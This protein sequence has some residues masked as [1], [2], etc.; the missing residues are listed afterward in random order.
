MATIVLLEHQLQPRLGIPYM[1]HLFAQHWERWGH[2]V[3][4]HRGVSAPPAADLAI[5]HVDLTVVP[6]PYRELAS[7]YPR[8]LNART[9]DIRK[10]AYSQA[11]VRKGDPWTGQVLVKTDANHGGHVD[12]ALRRMALAEGLANDVP[13]RSLM[14]HYYL[15]DS[16]ARVPDSIWETPGVLVEKFVPELDAGGGYHLRVYT[17]CGKEERS[18]RYRSDEPLVRAA[19]YV[20]REPVEVP[21]VVRRWREEMGFDIGKLDYV[22]HD[23][24]FVLLDANRTPA[25]PGHFA[26]DPGVAA[27]FERLAHG[28][29]GFL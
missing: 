7:R 14:D 16:Q 2:R 10:S 18:T 29:E 13:Q 25:A 12:D 24:Q 22:L 23:G 20:S 9:W 19:N 21:P 15:C 3:L 11:R 28:I 1:A 6:E 17:F 5:L 26:S 4:Y 8:V 27:S